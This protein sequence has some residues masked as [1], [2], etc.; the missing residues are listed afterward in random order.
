MKQADL[1]RQ[2]R[3]F[4]DSLAG[5]FHITSVYRN[6][7]NIIYLPQDHMPCV[8]P[9]TKDIAAIPNAWKNVEV[10]FRP[11][12]TPIPNPA[13]RSQNFQLKLDQWKKSQTK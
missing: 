10:P 6:Q 12:L 2:K 1:L 5:T 9:N 3:L 7:G 13:L 4:N 11:K 8:K